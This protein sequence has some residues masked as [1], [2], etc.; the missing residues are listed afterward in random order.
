MQIAIIHMQ[1]IISAKTENKTKHKPISRLK[2]VF[3]TLPMKKGGMER[4][5]HTANNS[6]LKFNSNNNFG[7]RI[8]HLIINHKW[9]FQHG[10]HFQNIRK[11]NLCQ[12]WI[13]SMWSV[14]EKHCVSSFCLPTNYSPF[15]IL[16]F[17]PYVG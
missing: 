7:C 5:A 13:L 17:V 3:L 1:G 12:Q 8:Y 15:I 10:L 9:V 11:T 4:L 2:S 14:C 6:K 16:M